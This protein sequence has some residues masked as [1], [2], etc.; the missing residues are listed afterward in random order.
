MIKSRLH[1]ESSSLSSKV[2]YAAKKR[3]LKRAWEGRD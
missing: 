1:G 2:R 3:E